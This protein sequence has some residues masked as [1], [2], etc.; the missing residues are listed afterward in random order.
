MLPLFNY[1]PG[2]YMIK[3]LVNGKCYIGSTNNLYRRY[4][5]HKSRLMSNNHS[6]RHLQNAWNKYGGDSLG[7]TILT[8]CELEDVRLFE[9]IYINQLKP[10]YNISPSA[11]GTFGISFSQEHKEK[12]SRA[13]KGKPSYQTKKYLGMVVLSPNGERHSINT[14]LRNFCNEYNLDSSSF[15][16]MLRGKLKSTGG[17]SYDTS[18]VSRQH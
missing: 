12:L 18:T 16:K 3:N 6:N 4:H 11:I 1:I 2:I 10:E 7:F 8:D 17:W 15:S 5:Q 14:S 13:K 9:Q